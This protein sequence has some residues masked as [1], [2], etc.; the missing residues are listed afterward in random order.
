MSIV[1]RFKAPTP[2]FFKKVIRVSLIISAGALAAL[3][4]DAAGKLLLPNFSFTLH[5]IAIIVCKNLF[6][7]GLV[8]AAIA[9][10]TKETEERTDQ[11]S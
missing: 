2:R 7:A 10:A 8:A 11:S 5:P 3:G 1:E 9:K 4:A 6:V